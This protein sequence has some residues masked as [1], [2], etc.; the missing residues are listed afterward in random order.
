MNISSISSFIMSYYQINFYDDIAGFKRSCNTL[1]N[2]NCNTLSDFNNAKIETSHSDIIQHI[3]SKD[4]NNLVIAPHCSLKDIS[5]IVGM[6][7]IPEY[8]IVHLPT[9]ISSF[10]VIPESPDSCNEIGR[11]D[12]RMLIRRHWK[13]ISYN[14]YLIINISYYK[15]VSKKHVERTLNMIDP[16]QIEE[17]IT[18]GREIVK[19]IRWEIKYYDS[20]SAIKAC[21]ASGHSAVIIANKNTVIYE[22]SQGEDITRG[23][24]INDIRSLFESFGDI[25]SITKNMSTMIN[26]LPE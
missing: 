18:P 11:F 19:S 20:S 22:I 10:K 13:I 3:I 15:K 21:R 8:H 1:S 23:A 9:I 12:G 26:Y 5:S 7:D 6:F 24:T 16:C 14:E 17:L 25:Q 2:F 4:P